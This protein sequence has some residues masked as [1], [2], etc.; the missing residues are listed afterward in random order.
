MDGADGKKGF[1]EGESSDLQEKLEAYFQ[2]H[3]II[4]AVRQRR[5]DLEDQG[6][7]GK[8]KGKFK[9]SDM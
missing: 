2:P 3:G 7:R 5:A 8:G 9:V 4:N 1:P 6:A